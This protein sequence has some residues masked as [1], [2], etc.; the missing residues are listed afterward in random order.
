MLSGRLSDVGYPS[1]CGDFEIFSAR[2]LGGWLVSV[3]KPPYGCYVGRKAVVGTAYD[4]SDSEKWS[5][6][7]SENLS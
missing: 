6:E 1:Y 7:E 5:R 4:D 3:S 2:A